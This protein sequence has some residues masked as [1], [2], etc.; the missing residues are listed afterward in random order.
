MLKIMSIVFFKISFVGVILSLQACYSGNVSS[1]NDKAQSASSFQTLSSPQMVAAPINDSQK[2][3]QFPVAHK[4]T[5]KPG[6]SVIVLNN[7]PIM[8]NSAG[9]HDLEI[10]LYFPAPHGEVSVQA[11]SS[12]GV[13]ILS[14]VDPAFF[15]VPERGEYRL[16]ISV[17]IQHEGRH[18]IHLNVS[19]MTKDV[20]QKRAVSVILQV[21]KMQSRLQKSIS[22]GNSGAVIE[23]PAQESI[24]PS[25]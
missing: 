6:A 5:T 3:S 18:Y 20:T 2:H 23:L 17:N 12:Q 15:P 25:H 7:Q 11:A 14:T 8:L 1:Q 16:P 21:G 22:S 4:K 24:S 19:V 10:L 9:V 13:Q